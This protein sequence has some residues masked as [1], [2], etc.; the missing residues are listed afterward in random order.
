MESCADCAE[1]P[2]TEV[3]ATWRSIHRQARTRVD[4][5]LAMADAMIYATALASGAQVVTMDAHF[6]GLPEAIVI[7]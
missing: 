1:K 5:R 3:C 4:R 6:K 7:A 2:Q